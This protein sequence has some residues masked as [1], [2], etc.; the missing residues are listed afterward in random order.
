MATITLAPFA[1]KLHSFYKQ[2]SLTTTRDSTTNHAILPT[3]LVPPPLAVS[4][5]L[6]VYDTEIQYSY[7]PHHLNNNP[8]LRNPNASAQEAPPAPTRPSSRVASPGKQTAHEGCM[9]EG[10]PQL[11]AEEAEFGGK[12]GGEGPAE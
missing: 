1:L 7:Q 8:P 12:E 11:Q 9:F 3:P 2:A 6:A 4:A 5:Y 10:D